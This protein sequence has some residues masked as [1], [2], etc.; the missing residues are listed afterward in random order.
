[1]SDSL[2]AKCST[3]F[4]RWSLTVCDIWW[5]A[6]S[7]VSTEPVRLN[8]T[9]QCGGLETKTRAE[10]HKNVW[11][12]GGSVTMSSSVDISY[13]LTHCKYQNINIY[14]VNKPIKINEA[15][16]ELLQSILQDFSLRPDVSGESE[17]SN[18]ICLRCA[19][20]LLLKL[21]LYTLRASLS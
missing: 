8:Q 5:R 19:F 16:K 20:I 10:R 18:C 13:H 1:M 2:A 14:Q 9:S 6:G 17:T 3:M 11:D 7:V 15:P 4:T 21:F 12:E